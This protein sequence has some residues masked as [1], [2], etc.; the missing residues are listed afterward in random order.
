MIEVE[1]Q[2]QPTEQELNTILKGA[3]FVGEKINHD[4][5]YDFSDYRLIKENI[6]LRSRNGSFELKIGKESG[7]T[8]EIE[9]EEKIKQYF[10]TNLELG[11][12]IEQN[13]EKIIDY[14]TNRKKYKKDN[15]TIDVDQLDFGYN[16]CE[17]E[18]MVTEESE[19]KEAQEKIS[20]FFKKYNLKTERIPEKREEYLR[21]KKPEIY[22]EIYGD[23]K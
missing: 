23:G 10:N 18:I 2:F 19:V 13:L 11:K 6:R 14:K 21:L 20:N 15:F 4:I 5:Y 16:L 12:F 8:E 3:Q 22:K 1:K 17:I 9:D 7:S